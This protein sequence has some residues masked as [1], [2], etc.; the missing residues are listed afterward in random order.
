MLSAGSLVTRADRSTQ[1]II[2]SVYRS[3]IPKQRTKREKVSQGQR[4]LA[5]S[6]EQ[7]PQPPER[8][9][10]MPNCA[11]EGCQPQRV[12]P[13]PII[14]QQAVL[15]MGGGVQV[16]VRSPYGIQVHSCPGYTIIDPYFTGHPSSAGQPL[17]ADH[18]QAPAH[19][20]GFQKGEPSVHTDNNQINNEAPRATNEPIN[21][22][23]P[24][25]VERP[26]NTT[27]TH[28]QEVHAPAPRPAKPIWDPWPD[29]DFERLYTTEELETTNLRTHWSMSVSGGSRDYRRGDRNAESWHGGFR[30]RRKCNGVIM[31]EHHNPNA[32]Y[33]FPSLCD[34]LVRPQT[35]WAGIRRQ[36]GRACPEC[37]GRLSYV[38][39]RAFSETYTFAGG[40]YFIHY[41]THHHARPPLHRDILPRTKTEDIE[42]EEILEEPRVGGSY[43]SSEDEEE[44]EETLTGFGATQPAFTHQSRTSSDTRSVGAHRSHRA[45]S[46]RMV[47]QRI[48]RS[49]RWWP[50]PGP[51]AAI[52]RR[53][54]EHVVRGPTTFSTQSKHHPLCH[55]KAIRKHFKESHPIP[56][57]E[58]ER[59]NPPPIPKREREQKPPP[60]PKREREQKPPPVP[61]RVQEQKKP[62]IPKRVHKREPYHISIPSRQDETENVF[63]ED[64]QHENSFDWIDSIGKHWDLLEIRSLHEHMQDIQAGMIWEAEAE[65]IACAKEQEYISAEEE[66]RK[67][68]IPNTV[69]KESAPIIPFRLYDCALGV[70]KS[71]EVYMQETNGVVPLYLVVSQVW[72]NIRVQMAMPSVAWHVPISDAEKW[73]AIRD[74]CQR[75]QIRWLWMDILCIDQMQNSPA[76]DQ[77]KAKEIPKMAAYYRGATACLVIP[78]RYEEFSKAYR[79]VKGVYSAFGGATSGDRITNNALAIW[80]SIGMMNTVVTDAWFSRIWTYQEFLLPKH[81]FLLDGQKLDVNDIQLIIDWYHKILRNGSLQ[82]PSEGKNYNFVTPGAERAIHGWVQFMNSSSRDILNRKGYL[83]LACAVHQ[84]RHKKC[85]RD[86]DRLFALYGLLPDDERVAVEVSQTCS[87]GVAGEPADKA[88]FRMKWVQTMEK[89]LEGGR[90]WPLLFDALDPDDITRGLHWMPRYTTRADTVRGVWC[91]PLYLHTIDLRNRHTI[92]VADDGLHI[93]VRRVGRITGASTNMGES[94]GELS[95]TIACIWLLMAKGFNINPILEQFKYGLTHTEQDAVLRDEVEG[96]HMVLEAALRADSLGECFYILEQAQLRSKLIYGAG[97]NDWN[98]RILCMAVKGQIRPIVFMAWIH[99]TK[100]LERGNCWVLDVTS[101]PLQTENRW[102]VANRHGPNTYTKIGTV[103]SCPAS[104]DIEDTFIRVILD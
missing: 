45:Q 65:A 93:A 80:N 29:G 96:A 100:K 38:N 91:G 40:K 66:R 78:D 71:H 4:I 94:G 1:D 99:S 37:G 18:A 17:H 35:R 74:Y 30:T 84:T 12:I 5:N 76:A 54:A 53:V 20:E 46:S 25:V 23:P 16:E 44:E 10:Q 24:P 31:C 60:I 77:E 2:R 57:Q 87:T 69:P 103:Y 19:P 75:K 47:F 15:Q 28:I 34:F 67:N 64:I 86:E 88:T 72:G 51:S 70:L 83:D 22:V 50:G 58:R 79:R 36:L 55:M 90:V 9:N 73:Y 101:E 68:T 6:E 85:A 21:Q 104:V 81:H 33:L 14:G 98:K 32:G 89:V 26:V 56:K 52:P 48:P 43:T 13:Q 41:D 7:I 59:Q 61:K 8:Q 63:P 95:K 11:C 97:L 82:K 92:Q 49:S 3:I 102:V 27:A 39:C 62:P 42:P